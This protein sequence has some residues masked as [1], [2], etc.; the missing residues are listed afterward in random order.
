MVIVGTDK[1]Q[2]ADTVMT[3]CSEQAVCVGAAS[4]DSLGY[5]APKDIRVWQE[6]V[7]DG[8]DSPACIAV[9]A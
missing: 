8:I 1:L 7:E 2:C 9:L 6:I 3:Y 5:A 4:A